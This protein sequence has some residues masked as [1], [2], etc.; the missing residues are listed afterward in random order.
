M[1]RPDL[2]KVALLCLPL[3]VCAQSPEWKAIACTVEEPALMRGEVLTFYFTESGQFRHHGDV[4]QT[5]DITSA[6]IHYCYPVEDGQ[7]CFTISRI[8]GRFS[9][10]GMA[11]KLGV[12]R[13]SGSCIPEGQ[14]PKF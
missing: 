1:T 11:S 9:F 3:P 14:K 7:A 10:L 13:M 2:L 5:A 12:H 4:P 6:E 8:S